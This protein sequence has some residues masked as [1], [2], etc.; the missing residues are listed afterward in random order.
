MQSFQRELDGMHR[1]G[2]NSADF[3][4]EIGRG[5]LHDFIRTPSAREMT[6]SR[7]TRH[8]RN[9][10]LRFEPDRAD[11]ARLYAAAEFEDIAADGIFDPNSGIGVLQIAS[12]TGIVEVPYESSGIHEAIVSSQSSTTQLGTYSGIHLV[13]IS[14]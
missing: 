11:R 13:V 9:A 14:H 3:I 7:A 8:G 6:D 4:D 1:C 5:Q 2:R 12:V 10:A